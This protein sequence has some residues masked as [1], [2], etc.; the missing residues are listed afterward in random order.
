MK[1]ERSLSQSRFDNI[2]SLGILKS[3]WYGDV[4]GEHFPH[5]TLIQKCIANGLCGYPIGVCHCGV[6]HV[7]RGL[8]SRL[9]H[10]TRVFQEIWKTNVLDYRAYNLE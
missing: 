7:R 9:S 10:P 1:R 8:S 3:S 4:R 5:V 2:I 6:I